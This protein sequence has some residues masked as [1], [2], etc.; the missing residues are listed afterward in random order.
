MND[1]IYD[2]WRQWKAKKH[3][4]TPILQRRITTDSV[5]NMTANK[6]FNYYLQATETEVSV[7]KLQA[8]Q[9][10][11]QDSETCIILYTY[12][13]ILLDVPT[14]EAKDIIPRIKSVIETGHFPV[15]IQVGNN[16]NKMNTISL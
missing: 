14:T 3:V 9:T 16:Y 4:K 11:L 5:N 10:L 2:L 6:L 12:D 7:Q 15:K 13:S 8:V 1:F